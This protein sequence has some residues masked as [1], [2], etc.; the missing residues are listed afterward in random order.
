MTCQLRVII[1]MFGIVRLIRGLVT[2][3][4]GKK[5]QIVRKLL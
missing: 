2:D 4:I 1:K 3:F 5:L